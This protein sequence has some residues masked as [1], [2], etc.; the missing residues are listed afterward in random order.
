MTVFFNILRD[1]L[2]ALSTLDV[3][4]LSKTSDVIRSM[5]RNRATAF[6]AA[7]LTQMDGFVAELLRLGKCAIVKAQAGRGSILSSPAANP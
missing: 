2:N 1:P 3:E 5:P 4:L 7:Y 6:E